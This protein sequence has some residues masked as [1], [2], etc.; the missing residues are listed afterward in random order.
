MI[1]VSGSQVG[2]LFSGEQIEPSKSLLSELVSSSGF[3]AVNPS[4]MEVILAKFFS[5]HIFNRAFTMLTFSWSP[6]SVRVAFIPRLA[7]LLTLALV[8]ALSVALST[9]GVYGSGA[10]WAGVVFPGFLW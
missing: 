4:S 2:F 8:L 10:L 6:L 7:P 9:G 3:I 1:F 5:H